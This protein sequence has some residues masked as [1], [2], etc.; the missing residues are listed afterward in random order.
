MKNI[1]KTLNFLSVFI[2]TKDQINLFKNIKKTSINVAILLLL[3][4]TSL[5]SQDNYGF[6]GIGANDSGGTGFKSI[7]AT[8]ILVTSNNSTGTDPNNGAVGPELFSTSTAVGG[9]AIITLKA[10]GVNATSFDVDDIN[11]WN[12][13]SRSGPANYTANTKIIFK[14]SS[15]TTIRSILAGT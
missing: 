13:L 5:Y 15:G 1:I 3:F 8:S 9:T 14:N 6:R 2:Y 7:S 12:Y 11:I 4:S 10:D